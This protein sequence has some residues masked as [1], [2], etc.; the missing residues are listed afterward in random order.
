MCVFWGGEECVL[1]FFHCVMIHYMHSGLKPHPFLIHSFLGLKFHM[2]LLGSSELILKMSAAISSEALGKNLLLSS[3][4]LLGE[5][6]DVGLSSPVLAASGWLLSATWGPLRVLA[7]DLLTGAV[8]HCSWQRDPSS[9]VLSWFKL[10][11]FFLC[12]QLEKTL[13]PTR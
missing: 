2:A 11:S 12:C 1:V 8:H 6:S 7:K 10:L 4:R 3:F 5:V 13:W 9:S